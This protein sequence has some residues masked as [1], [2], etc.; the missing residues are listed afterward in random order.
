MLDF[1]ARIMNVLNS[2]TYGYQLNQNNFRLWKLD[3]LFNSSKLQ[4]FIQKNE[5]TLQNYINSLIKSGEDA[6]MDDDKQ[7]DNIEKNSG[8]EFP[9]LQL[10]I[11]KSKSLEKCMIA[12]N[13]LVIVER[14]NSKGE[15][16]FKYIKNMKIGKCEYC[17]HEKPLAVCCK[18]EE[19]IKKQNPLKNAHSN[20]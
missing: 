16:L 6:S 2:E 5:K 7:D 12:F 18:C 3:P 8:V 13:D 14:A 19:V 15:F 4:N 20:P 9:G 17:Y 10:D 1:K 11:Y